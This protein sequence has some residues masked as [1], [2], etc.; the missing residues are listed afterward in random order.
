MIKDINDLECADLPVSLYVHYPFCLR[1]CPY[2]DFYSVP[3][4]RC[5]VTDKGYVAKLCA[6]FRQFLPY[7][8]R[9]KLISIFIGGGTPSLCDPASL[10][11]LLDETREHRAEDCEI[12]LEVN[13]KT[14]NR[15]NF[16]D[17]LAMG[18][19]RISLGVQSFNDRSLAALGRVHRSSDALEAVKLMANRVRVNLDIMHGLP[20]QS[21]ED[22]LADLKIACDSGCEHLSWYELTIEE[23]TPFYDNPPPLPC[24][25]ELAAI[26]DEGFAYLK[27]QGFKRYEVSAFT[28]RMRCLHNQNYWRFGDYAG[29][30]AGAHGKFTFK[31]PAGTLKIVRTVFNDDYQGYLEASPSFCKVEADDIAFEYL[32]NRLRL[33]DK[34][35]F[36]QMHACCGLK[37]EGA[38]ADKLKRAQDLKLLELDKT[39]F[40]LTLQGKIMLNDILAMFL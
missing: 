19:N 9:R 3:K 40:A 30:G 4:P 22:A 20:G 10:K 2:C 14:L 33:F 31:T 36:A 34:I 35:S 15:R 18:I 23:G 38:L 24:E 17:Y 11:L 27:G 1:K 6:D 5:G 7:L 13:P 28:R 16:E 32:L 21:K 8:G 12:T 37:F 39:G 26:E 25:D 29:I